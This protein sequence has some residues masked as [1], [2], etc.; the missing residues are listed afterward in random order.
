VIIVL[1]L[2]VVVVGARQLP[3]RDTRS[4]LIGFADTF[5]GSCC[6]ISP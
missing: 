6:R 5:G 3:W 2:I 1:V 4:L